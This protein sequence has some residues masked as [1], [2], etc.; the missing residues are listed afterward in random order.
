MKRL[1]HGKISLVDFMRSIK[2]THPRAAERPVECTTHFAHFTPH[3]R[4]EEQPN[5]EE[6][7][8]VRSAN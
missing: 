5:A 8:L 2:F 4:S 6:Q 1:D 3:A 7:L